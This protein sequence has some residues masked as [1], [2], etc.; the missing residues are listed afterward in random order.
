MSPET[1]RLFDIVAAVAYLRAIG[2][3]AATKNF[4]R[5]LIATGQ[6]AHVR[7]GKKFYVSREGLD[8]WISKRQRRTQ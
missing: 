5:G 8:A 7:V 1:P 2:A 3:D 6:I 4:V